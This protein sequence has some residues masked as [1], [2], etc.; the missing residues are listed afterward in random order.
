MLK[1]AKFWRKF[2]RQVENSFVKVKE[3][4]MEDRDRHY[5]VVPHREN[6]MIRIRK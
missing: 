6:E 3:I 2:L 4:V 5:I 1:I